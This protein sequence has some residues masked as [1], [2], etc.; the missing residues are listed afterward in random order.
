MCLLAL[1][2]Q[3]FIPHKASGMQRFSISAHVIPH[4]NE[5]GFGARNINAP[6]GHCGGSE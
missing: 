6:L 5:L 1:V 4:H 3:E 2:M